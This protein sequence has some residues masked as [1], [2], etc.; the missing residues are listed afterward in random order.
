MFSYACFRDPQTHRRSRLNCF[1]EAVSLSSAMP[2][3]WLGGGGGISSKIK[4]NYEDCGTRLHRGQSHHER[5]WGCLTCTTLP[6][7]AAIP[8]ADSSLIF[9]TDWRIIFAMCQMA[10]TNVPPRQ[11]FRGSPSRREPPACFMISGSIARNSGSTSGTSRRWGT[12]TTRKL[13]RPWHP[14]E[15]Q[16]GRSCHPRSPRTV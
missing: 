4:T 2:L 5:P 11:G 14:R 9:F 13:E 15:E 3:S 12:R 10:L 7:P 16:S 8:L 1:C 6:I